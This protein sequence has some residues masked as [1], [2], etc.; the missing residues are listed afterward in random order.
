[1]A[2]HRFLCFVLLVG[3]S[4]CPPA[5]AA[6]VVN[7]ADFSTADGGCKDLDTGLVWSSDMR[8]FVDT[9]SGFYASSTLQAP[10]NE[11]L[12]QKPENGGGLPIGVARRF[13]RFR[14]LWPTGLIRI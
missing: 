2:K 12:N 13:R 9:Q 3:Y 4:W 7:D 8:S 11:F 1:M 5:P 14:L 10:C 6:C